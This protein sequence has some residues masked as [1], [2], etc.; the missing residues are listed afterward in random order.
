MQGSDLLCW[1]FENTTRAEFIENWGTAPKYRG[2]L[3]GVFHC[4][5]LPFQPSIMATEVQLAAREPP[6]N[7]AAGPGLFPPEMRHG[8]PALRAPSAKLYTRIVDPHY[9]PKAPRHFSVAWLGRPGEEP[10]LSA[11]K[12]P[13]SLLST[14]MRLAELVRA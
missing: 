8:S 9:I 14:T 5:L 7:E 2:N 10:A 12:K 1:H 11:N 3:L 6:R 13:M 4:G